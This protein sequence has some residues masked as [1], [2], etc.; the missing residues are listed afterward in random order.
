MFY[1]WTNV[2]PLEK[3]V[4]LEKMGHI[5]KKKDY[6]SK[7]VTFKTLLYKHNKEVCMVIKL[8]VSYILYYTILRS[9]G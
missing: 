4:T 6:I 7:K 3:W 1:A 5:W 9:D 8:D 2:S